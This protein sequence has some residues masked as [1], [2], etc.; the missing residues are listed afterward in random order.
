MNIRS[1]MKDWQIARLM[2]QE[3]SKTECDIVKS[4]RKHGSFEIVKYDLEPQGPWCLATLK[5]SDCSGW[6]FPTYCLAG[7]EKDLS[8][9]DQ[10]FNLKAGS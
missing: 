4:L 3:N 6:L 5:N 1:D 8:P 2:F 9:E 7:R 10:V